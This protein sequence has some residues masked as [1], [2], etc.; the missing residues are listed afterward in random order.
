MNLVSEFFFNDKK[1]TAK[2]ETSP[3]VSS[4]SKSEKEKFHLHKKKLK[5]HKHDD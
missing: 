3:Q 1:I 2:A 4:F 5:T